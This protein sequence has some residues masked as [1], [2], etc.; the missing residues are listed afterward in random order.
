MGFVVVPIGLVTYDPEINS[1]ADFKPEDKIAVAIPR[2]YPA[3][4][5][6]HGL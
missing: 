4:S 6:C 1:L 5:P 3:Y 2:Q